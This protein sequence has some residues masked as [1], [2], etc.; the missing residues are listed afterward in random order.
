MEHH[1]DVLNGLSQGIVIKRQELLEARTAELQEEGEGDGRGPPPQAAGAGL[2][3]REHEKEEQLHGQPQ[4][5]S[6]DCLVQSVSD[7]DLIDH[8]PLVS[9]KPASPHPQPTRLV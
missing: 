1:N 8:E 9:G 5:D 4:F 7:M 3:N 6:G 2:V